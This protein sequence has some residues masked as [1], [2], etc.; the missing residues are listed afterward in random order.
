MKRRLSQKDFKKMLLDSNDNNRLS[1]AKL[2]THL[3]G[4]FPDIYAFNLKSGDK[5]DVNNI[6]DEILEKVFPTAQFT[7]SRA[8]G[9][10]VTT[11]AVDDLENEEEDE[12]TYVNNSYLESALNIITDDYICS[13]FP[14]QI[15]FYYKDLTLDQIQVEAESLLQR[16][17]HKPKVN[18]AAKIS[19]ICF[20]GRDYFTTESS[21]KAT[22][23]DLDLHY[24]DDFGDEC[25][26]IVEFLNS[27][28]SGLVLLHGPAGT[29]KTTFIRHL[30]T[31]CPK[32]YILI[33]PGMMPHMG[34]PEFISFI[35]SHKNSVF[36]LED[37]EQ[38]LVDRQFNQFNNGI[39]TVLNMSDGLLS[40]IFNLKFICTFNAEISAIDPA[41][42]RPGRCYG[43]YKF[44]PLTKEKVAKLAEVN[45]IKLP[46][47][48]EMVLA[49]LFN[50]NFE[51][52]PIEENKKIGF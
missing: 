43:N 8:S 2:F 21:I 18:E 48:K 42:T 33:P 5:L 17:P 19:L 34:S 35:I 22:T 51:A 3:Y 46:E 29:G 30:I 39:S 49:D 32:E 45:N 12:F 10:A 31:N 20:D 47:V 6:D 37:C 41:L 52:K 11:S 16:L 28:E 50:E 38:L 44:K 9:S 36:V 4:V 15:A 24:N 7:W 40:D 1:C 27:R 26:K 23:I 14:E 25:T 13:I